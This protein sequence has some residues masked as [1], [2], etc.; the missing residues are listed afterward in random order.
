MAKKETTPALERTYNVPLRR[1]YL[2]APNWKRTTKAVI[3]LREFLQRHMKSENVIIGNSINLVLWKHGI[4]NPPHHVK[5][6]ATKDD[7]GVVRAELFGVKA[8]TQPKEKKKTKATPKKE[9]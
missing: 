4:K 7:K 3:A 6:T 1:E 5:V 8:A 9:A 2:K